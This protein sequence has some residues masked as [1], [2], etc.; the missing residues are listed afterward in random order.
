MMH[1]PPETVDPISGGE[2]DVNHVDTGGLIIVMK[3][4]VDKVM[5]IDVWDDCPRYHLAM[6]VMVEQVM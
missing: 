6:T 2:T 1:Q 4:I 3:V 5:W